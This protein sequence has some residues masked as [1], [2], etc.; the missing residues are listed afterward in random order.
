MI[1]PLGSVDPDASNVHVRLVQSG[2]ANDAVGAVG[3]VTV[4]DW[5][6]LEVAPKLSVTV[7]VILCVP[8]VAKV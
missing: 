4:T 3:A 1:V 8:P 2:V 7:R 5:V 6:E